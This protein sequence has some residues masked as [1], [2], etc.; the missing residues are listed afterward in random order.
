MSSDAGPPDSV[1]TWTRRALSDLVD[2]RG[3]TY[4]VVQ[5]G[6]HRADGTPILRV[7]NITPSGLRLDDPMRIDPDIAARHDRSRLTGGEVLITLVGSVGQVAVAPPELAGWNVARAVGVIPVREEIP[8]Q[9]VAWCL[10]TPEARQYLG[11]RLN[12]TVQA[13]LNLRDLSAV[14]IPIPPTEVLRDIASV[15]GALDAKLDNNRHLCIALEGLAMGLMQHS[16]SVGSPMSWD[17]GWP[18]TTLG[19]VLSVLETGNRPRGGVKGITSGVPS[20]GAESIVGVGIFDFAKLK[21]VPRDYYNALRRGRVEDRDVLLYKDGGRPGD[22]Q[23]HV[24]MV[25]EGFP[26]REAAINEHVYRLRIEPPFTQDFLYLWLRSDRLTQEM[27]RRGTGVAIPGLNSKA[28]KALP[29][30]RPDVET[31]ERVQ[32]A[33]A[34]ALSLI[35]RTAAESRSLIEVRDALLPKLVRGEIRVPNTTDPDESN[36]DAATISAAAR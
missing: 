29:I 35:L 22:F 1:G 17:R 25:G 13:T 20:I 9:W 26:F 21:F 2:R 30:I 10:Q 34:P 19:E 18:E 31:L 16:L 36:Q 4:G 15:L 32:D 7:N 27:R 3:I 24:S 6:H 23:P 28:V 11:E 12:T 8:P 5:P 33:V 14:Q